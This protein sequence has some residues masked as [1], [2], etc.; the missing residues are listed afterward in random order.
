MARASCPTRISAKRPR[1][2]LM[3]RAR[4]GPALTVW[5]SISKAG[6]CGSSVSPQL[7]F[8]LGG[9]PRGVKSGAEACDQAF[10]AVIDQRLA[11]YGRSGGQCQIAAGHFAARPGNGGVGQR[12][13]EGR[14]MERRDGRLER[15]L[16]KP[17][18]IDRGHRGGLERRRPRR[19]SDRARRQQLRRYRGRVSYTGILRDG[20]LEALWH[21]V[22]GRVLTA[23]REGE[24]AR[25]VE[26]GAW[27]AFGVSLDTFERVETS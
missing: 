6:P 14:L 2:L 20:K 17:V 11:V 22:S 5:R 8:A 16:A 12:S 4:C 23:D 13:R 1:R 24:P 18:R 15:D 3:E 9:K 25:S 27:R 21:T 26:I 7:L 10:S 19:L